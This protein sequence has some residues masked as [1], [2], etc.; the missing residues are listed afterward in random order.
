M[1]NV[2]RQRVQVICTERDFEVLN[3]VFA[4]SIHGFMKGLESYELINAGDGLILYVP[5][6]WTEENLKVI[7]F[8]SLD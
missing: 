8:R 2:K 6:D 3:D 1:S 5:E 7:Q 4:Q